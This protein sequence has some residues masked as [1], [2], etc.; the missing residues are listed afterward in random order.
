[1]VTLG[2]DITVIATFDVVPPTVN[3]H[4]KRLKCRKGFR[5]RRVK[6][7]AR[8]V[9]V[10]KRR[11]RLAAYRLAGGAHEG[12]PGSFRTTSSLRNTIRV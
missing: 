1:V 4:K 6:G 2:A 7:K 5:K 10:K 9:K 12:S 3:V 8:C 11:R